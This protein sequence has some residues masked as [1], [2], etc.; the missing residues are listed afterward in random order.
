MD[1]A[2]RLR[3]RAVM[4]CPHGQLRRSCE[5]CERDEEIDRLKEELY[6]SHSNAAKSMIALGEKI[7][8]F[9]RA[10]ARIAAAT[11]PPREGSTPAEDYRIFAA[12]ALEGK[13]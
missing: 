11:V 9:R 6:E 7:D 2:E 8:Y 1:E 13:Q 4:L 12:E 3:R 10:L 5:L